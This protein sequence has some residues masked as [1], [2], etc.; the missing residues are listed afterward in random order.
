MG[1]RAKSC[2]GGGHSI[3][4][5]DRFAL[6]YAVHIY[7]SVRDFVRAFFKDFPLGGG[8]DFLKRDLSVR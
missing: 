1:V 8:W 6:C 2:W 5:P 7:N 3:G 4:L